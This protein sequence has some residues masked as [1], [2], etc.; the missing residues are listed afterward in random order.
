MGAALGASRPA[1]PV[2]LAEAQ[3][4]LGM[5]QQ[6]RVDLAQHVAKLKDQMQ[7]NKD[8]GLRVIAR[9]KQIGLERQHVQAMVQSAQVAATQ[10]REEALRQLAAQRRAAVERHVS[11]VLGSLEK[12]LGQVSLVFVEPAREA[13]LKSLEPSEEVPKA[14]LESAGAIAKV[15]D[16]LKSELDPEL[17]AQ[18]AALGQIQREFCDVAL[19]ACR[20]AWG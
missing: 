14:V 11:E 9:L 2:A 5:L 15:V 18:D 10:G 3:E 17:L 8:E 19:S 4:G 13:M 7:K 20:T 16:K 1:R 6:A 12:S